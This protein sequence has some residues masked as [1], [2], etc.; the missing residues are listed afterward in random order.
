MRWLQNSFV[1]KEFCNHL[2]KYMDNKFHIIEYFLSQK[3]LLF[4]EFT[5]KSGRVSPYFFNLGCLHTGA[6][7]QMLGRFYAQSIVT[8]WGKDFDIVFG[9]AYKGIPLAV[10]TVE[11]LFDEQGLDVS[12]SSNRKEMKNYADR[13]ILLGSDI[14]NGDRIILV[15]D[16]VT[17]GATKEDVITLIQTLANVSFT[18]LVIA[19]DR[20]ERNESSS[21][22]AVLEFSKKTGIPVISMITAYDI[23]DY[24]TVTRHKNTCN[25]A[26]D[27]DEKM[28]HYLEKYGC[29]R[30]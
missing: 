26:K 10:C 17:T 12:Y 7:L 23:L 21:Q 30:H 11:A 15:D 8:A 28:S 29:Q 4:G 13:S 27:C 19:L 6:Q 5:L 9:P 3:A 16:V 22:T 1:T 14:K 2:Y 20:V 24:I 18:G 25:L